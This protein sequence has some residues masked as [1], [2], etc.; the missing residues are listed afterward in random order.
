MELN[1]WQESALGYDMLQSWGHHLTIDGAV[2]QL[3]GAAVK[4]GRLTVYGLSSRT[5]RKQ[6][7]KRG[8][9]NIGVFDIDILYLAGQA[10]H[11]GRG[12]GGSH[13]R[14][15]G[16]E[17]LLLTAF[18]Q[19]GFVPH[20]QLAAA[21][22]ED[23]IWEEITFHEPCFEL[24]AQR[25]AEIKVTMGVQ[26]AKE[27]LS[28]VLHVPL[29]VS[30]EEAV[31]VMTS[32]GGQTL[33]WTKAEVV[34]IWAKTA[35]L[36]DDP[37]CQARFTAEELETQKGFMQEA[38]ASLCPPEMRLVEVQYEWLE[39][40]TSLQMRLIDT[41]PVELA[42][43]CSDMIFMPILEKERGVHG[44]KI[45]AEI[46][47]EPVEAD[48][49][50]LDIEL[51]DYCYTIPPKDQI[52]VKTEEAQ[53]ILAAAFAASGKAWR[54]LQEGIA[55]YDELQVWGH[56]LKLGEGCV[57][58]AGLVRSQ[59]RVTLYGIT[60][61]PTGGAANWLGT[62]WSIST[63]SG[64]WQGRMD[65]CT[66]LAACPWGEIMVLAE[67]LRQG[68]MPYPAFSWRE[69][70]DLRWF[71]WTLSGSYDCLPVPERPESVKLTLASERQ[72]ELDFARF[73]QVEPLGYDEV[74]LIGRHADTADK[75]LQLLG[76]LRQGETVRLY[77][78]ARALSP[79]SRP[80]QNASTEVVWEVSAEQTLELGEQSIAFGQG[81]CRN[82]EEDREGA[83]ILS[84]FQR[85]GLELGGRFSSQPWDNLQLFVLQAVESMSALPVWAPEEPCQL[86][87]EA[88][89]DSGEESLAKKQRLSF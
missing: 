46:L 47:R 31:S 76:L 35:A 42:N 62:D 74:R 50:A 17:W 36:Y 41:P 60:S 37:A 88:S 63:G 68:F 45:H 10:Y 78:L 7:L 20:S 65:G 6:R 29:P 87:W 48:V 24:P 89:V 84:V 34:D 1:Y 12:S 67:F 27:P 79:N 54:Q 11:L 8:Q 25:P 23:L 61:I 32:R 71:S 77:G 2:L 72:E 85:L 43:S 57:Q 33:Y 49:T 15:V 4:A 5:A 82:L 83:A 81:Q 64:K 80:S 40:D 53:E 56:Y 30:E 38:L 73:W 70:K 21:P 55:A 69:M 26:H 9:K 18:L 75:A 19:Q 58:L 39:E 3:V 86:C 22:L 14:Y 16:K 66:D 28:Q 52:F 51:T 59:E 44:G 13:L